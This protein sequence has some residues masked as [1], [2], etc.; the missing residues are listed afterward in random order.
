MRYSFPERK[1]LR[2]LCWALYG[3]LLFRCLSYDPAAD[4]GRHSA[5][6][7]RRPLSVSV[8]GEVRRPGTYLF[9][10]PCSVMQAIQTAGGPARDADLGRLNLKVPLFWNSILRVPSLHSGFEPVISLN[11]SS[12]MELIEIPG[13][14]PELA[15]RIVRHREKIGPF[16]DEE[17]LLHVPGI[18]RKKLRQIME[19]AVLNEDKP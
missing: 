19:H 17:D 8:T 10:E 12:A 9:D 16:K 3:V 14:G 2:F 1:I 6:E 4:P 7:G 18:G 15:G 5:E 11:R 13:I